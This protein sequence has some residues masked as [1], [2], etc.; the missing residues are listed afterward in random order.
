[1][2]EPSILS[3]FRH[4]FYCGLIQLRIEGLQRLVADDRVIEGFFSILWVYG[5]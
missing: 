4:T 5:A 2:L 1:M 3:Y